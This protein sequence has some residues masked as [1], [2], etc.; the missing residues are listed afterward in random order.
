MTDTEQSPTPLTRIQNDLDD[1]GERMARLES[2][3][4]ALENQGGRKPYGTHRPGGGGYGSPGQ[5]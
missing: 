1:M 5:F 4:V 2:R 3:I